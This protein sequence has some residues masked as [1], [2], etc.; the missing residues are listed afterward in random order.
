MFSYWCMSELELF[1]ERLRPID[2]TS[3]VATADS[4]LCDSTAGTTPA[5]CEN[6]DPMAAFD[7]GNQD[8][9]SAAVPPGT[10]VP[11]F[12]GKLG[13]LAIQFAEPIQVSS[14]TMGVK[15]SCTWDMPTS[16]VLQGSND[17]SSWQDLDT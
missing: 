11:D 5:H 13:F 1:D 6:W 16:W 2:T 10:R 17:G 9:C 8:Y 12:E 4:T 14:Y 3:V 7:G 15:G